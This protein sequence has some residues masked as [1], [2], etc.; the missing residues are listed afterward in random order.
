[1]TS[2]ATTT[3]VHA[4]PLAP[5]H[6]G[7]LGLGS[8]G[9]GLVA[10][11][12]GAGHLRHAD[13]ASW[14]ALLVALG[15]AV[16]AYGLQRLRRPRPVTRAEAVV[17]A[18]VGAAWA[19]VATSGRVPT[20][21]VPGSGAGADAALV[22]LLLLLA[23]AAAVGVRAGRRGPTEAARTG[24]RPSARAWSVRLAGW[25][26]GA[27]LVAAL[28]ASGLTATEAGDHAVDHG[29]HGTPAQDAGTGVGT[30]LP[31]RVPG[32]PSGHGDH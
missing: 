22:A 24:P 25:A 17:P 23:G 20:D 8:A 11:A 32:P 18:L 6:L 19:A 26:A 4:S 21:G 15:A 2:A 28:T 9:A 7:L 5:A 1:M 13:G 29:G 30:G 12:L 3:P 16:G 10:V 14:G 27:L 31:P